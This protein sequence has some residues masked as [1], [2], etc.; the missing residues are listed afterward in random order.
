MNWGRPLTVVKGAGWK[1]GR[2]L[3]CPRNCVWLWPAAAAGWFGLKQINALSHG[4]SWKGYT[5]RAFWND[6]L[7]SHYQ[8]SSSHFYTPVYTT[9][10][11]CVVIFRTHPVVVQKLHFLCLCV[12][13]NIHLG[14]PCCL[15]AQK[16]WLEIW[17]I[18]IV[19]GFRNRNGAL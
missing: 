1:R 11:C 9:T 2:S 17:A 10:A 18:L 14:I 12:R 4:G 5:V 3:S 19:K 15:F 16:P 13:R 8:N 6:M 7:H